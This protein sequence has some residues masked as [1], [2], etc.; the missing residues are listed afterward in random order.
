MAEQAE[1]EIVEEARGKGIID[2]A[3][4][5]MTRAVEGI[6]AVDVMRVLDR[7]FPEWRQLGTTKA[8]ELIHE[9]ELAV[10][11]ATRANLAWWSMYMG[12]DGLTPTDD[13]IDITVGDENMARVHVAFG[14]A[15]DQ[16]DRRGFMLELA[17]MI[18]EET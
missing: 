17:R 5:V 7:E 16:D 9:I 12:R 15:F 10:H 18:V 14:E 2:L 3:A 1:L 6:H 8:N 11:L 13:G 4:L